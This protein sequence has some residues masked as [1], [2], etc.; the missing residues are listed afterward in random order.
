MSFTVFAAM[1]KTPKPITALVE[2]PTIFIVWFVMLFVRC[3]LVFLFRVFLRLGIVVI[4]S[5]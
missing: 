1:L 3:F 4:C 2:S 5:F